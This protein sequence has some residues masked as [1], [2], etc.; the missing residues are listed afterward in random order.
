MK[1][2]KL[3][4]IEGLTFEEK[5]RLTISFLEF[6]IKNYKLEFDDDPIAFPASTTV[7]ILSDLRDQV[8]RVREM[9]ENKKNERGISDTVK[10]L[11]TILTRGQ[12]ENTCRRLNYFLKDAL[13]APLFLKVYDFVDIP[14][15]EIVF[16]QWS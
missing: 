11:L 14:F 15:D 8:S 4:F 1:Q 10:D 9:P 5:R 7:P 13:P 16:L 3:R 6:T 12:K 2:S